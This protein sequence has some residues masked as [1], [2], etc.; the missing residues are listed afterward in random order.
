MD[1]LNALLD[2]TFVNDPLT[3]LIWILLSALLA[4]G[5]WFLANRIISGKIKTHPDR[6]ISLHYTRQTLHF[7]TVVS[8]AIVILYQFEPLQAVSTSLLAG[9]GVIAVIAGFAGQEALSNTVSGLFLRLFRPFRI[10]ERITVRGQNITGTVESITLRHT[11]LRAVNNNR[12]IIPNSV[13]NTAI[14]ENPA[15]IDAEMVQ[16]FDIG[17]S[18][19]TDVK[20]AVCLIQQAALAH[21]DCLDRRTDAEKAEGAPIVR[22]RLISFGESSLDLRAYIWVKDELTGFCLACDLRET[23]KQA[24]DENGI[25]IPFPYR[26]VILRKDS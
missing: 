17:V 6:A 3:S 11:V 1:K 8:A 15:Y 5:M 12:I 9:S 24:F 10:G 26:T 13:L 19:D 23:V 2:Q 16:Y 22:V 21:P 4:V 14:V 7:L 25:E 20:R 18:Y